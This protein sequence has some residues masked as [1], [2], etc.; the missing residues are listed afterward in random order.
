VAKKGVT[1]GNG[2]GKMKSATFRIGHMGDHNLETIERCLSAC[3]S[4]LRS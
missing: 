3:S 4:V 1:V 2:Y